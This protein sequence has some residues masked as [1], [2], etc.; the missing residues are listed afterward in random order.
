MKIYL[1]G[2]KDWRLEEG[3][4]ARCDEDFTYK[5]LFSFFYRKDMDMY[6]DKFSNMEF[7]LGDNDADKD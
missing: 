1:A 7:E 3:C 4:I 2:A 5:R 6:V